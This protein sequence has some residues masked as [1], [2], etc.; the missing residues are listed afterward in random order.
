MWAEFNIFKESS[1]DTIGIK[2][3]KWWILTYRL[4]EYAKEDYPWNKMRFPL[5]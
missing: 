3:I 4:F 2:L 5:I 1:Q